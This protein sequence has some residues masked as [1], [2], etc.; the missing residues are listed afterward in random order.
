MNIRQWANRSTRPE[1]V[2]HRNYLPVYIDLGTNVFWIPETFGPETNM[3]KTVWFPMKPLSHFN[4]D[5]YGIACCP[6]NIISEVLLPSVML[7]SLDSESM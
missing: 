3:F 1:N 2:Q 7:C 4:G 5:D 6:G